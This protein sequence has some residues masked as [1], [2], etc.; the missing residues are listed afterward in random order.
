[1][2]YKHFK[3]QIIIYFVLIAAGLF[4]L[5]YYIFIE[6]NYIRIF[7][8]AIFIVLML[9]ALFYYINKT[10]RDLSF[11][12]NAVL[13]D[14]FTTKYPENPR[15]NSFKEFY[16]ALGIINKRFV[17]QSQRE[18][19]EYQYIVTLISQMQTGVLI[20]DDQG[21]IH[22]VNDAFTTLIKKEQ[23]ID[24]QGINSSSNALYNAIDKLKSNSK[25]TLK[26]KINEQMHE[27]SIA[28]SEMK[29]KQ[30]QYKIVS[31]QDIKNELDLNEMQAWHKLIR[32]LTHEIMNSVSPI[33][34]LSSTLKSIADKPEELETVKEGLDAIEQRSRSLLAFTESY[35]KLTRV[36]IP[37]I[38]KI[39]SKVFFDNILKLMKPIF[40]EQNVELTFETD[41]LKNFEADPVL[42]EQVIINLL[43][44]AAEAVGNAGHVSV[45]LVGSNER[46]N[47]LVKDNGPGIA[48][49]IVDQI[50]IPFYTTKAEGS[51]IGLSL[52]RQIIN[53]HGGNLTFTTS[54]NGTTFNIE[55]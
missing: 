51:G 24:I 3:I 7:F 42:L 23:L 10:N 43:K 48:E 9:I 28:A 20:Y 1:M 50:F 16:N 35:R 40:D 13:H 46:T 18:A 32:V 52:S 39:E 45:Q 6:L 44:N 4:G 8:L 54:S 14:D 25:I 5:N 17:N 33:S 19:S 21:R 12:L 30:N 37:K 29:M 47:I 2:T 11:F 15:G 27:L 22:L 26:T 31:V 34:S 49:D 55:L 36:P 41:A 53:Q 38:Q